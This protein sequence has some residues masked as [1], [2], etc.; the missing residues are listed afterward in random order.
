MDQARDGVGEEVDEFLKEATISGVKDAQALTNQEVAILL[1]KYRTTN[2]QTTPGFCP[3]PMVI[4]TQAYLEQVSGGAGKN[5]EAAT[6]I[7]E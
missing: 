5:E 3:P 6:A 4:K 7:R 2:V 1:D